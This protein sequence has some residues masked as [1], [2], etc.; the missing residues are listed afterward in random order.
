MMGNQ[1]ISAGHLSYTYNRNP[2][3]SFF[4][5]D[6]LMNTQGNLFRT[7]QVKIETKN[8]FI[9]ARHYFKKTEKANLKVFSGNYRRAVKIE[10]IFLILP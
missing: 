2:R 5:L 4:L 1:V 8:V 3:Q 10:H 7:S 6:K 9:P